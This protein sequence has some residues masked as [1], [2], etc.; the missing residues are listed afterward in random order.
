MID[1]DNARN[2]RR[3][4]I[5]KRVLTI[6]IEKAIATEIC[7][8]LMTSTGQYPLVIKPSRYLHHIPAF[9]LACQG[10]P[11]VFQPRLFSR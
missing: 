2:P 5:D 3:I 10:W 11:S 4:D 9:L 8:T 6:E 7:I 1:K